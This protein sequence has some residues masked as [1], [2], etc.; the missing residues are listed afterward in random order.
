MGEDKHH[1]P[2]I[3]TY[4]NATKSGF[5][6]PDKLVREHLY[7]INEVLPFVIIPQFECC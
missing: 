1:K 6:I 3:I 2:E 7:E 5:D 4:Y